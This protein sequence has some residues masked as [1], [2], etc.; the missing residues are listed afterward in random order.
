[1][2]KKHSN[3][4]E[5]SGQNWSN[6]DWIRGTQVL[7]PKTLRA[8]EDERSKWGA[9]TKEHACI[10][11]LQ[12]WPTICL[13]SAQ[14]YERS[15]TAFMCCRHDGCY[16][17]HGCLLA[18]LY[19]KTLSSC[20]LICSD[21]IAS[22][23]LL[24]QQILVVHFWAW[25]LC[26]PVASRACTEKA[27]TRFRLEAL[28]RNLRYQKLGGEGA[29][30]LQASGP[31]TVVLCTH[32]QGTRTMHA[33]QQRLGQIRLC[34]ESR[35]KNLIASTKK[36]NPYVRKNRMIECWQFLFDRCLYCTVFSSDVV[37][38]C[39][40]SEGALCQLLYS[41][42]WSATCWCKRDRP[43]EIYRIFIQPP[44]AVIFHSRS[45]TLNNRET[46]FQWLL[47]YSCTCACVCVCVCVCVCACTVIRMYV[48]FNAV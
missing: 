11:S 8:R 43:V 15:P 46:S 32:T 10:V 30:Q 6:F 34:F 18:S 3:R 40:P 35:E 41:L 29:P 36:A 47:N 27:K 17:H 25:L 48:C 45:F 19:G 39:S 31:Q 1:M 42:L 38:S 21:C 37:K 33:P 20:F 16:V 44:L 13:G 28:Q 9:E 24:T 5:Q 23:M 26:F 14:C 7:E 2:K 22:E 12:E 4:G